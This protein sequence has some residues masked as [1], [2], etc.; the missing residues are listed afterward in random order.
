MKLDI[1]LLVNGTHYPVTIEPRETLLFVLR[2]RLGLTGSKYV[3]GTGECGACTVIVN[4]EPKLSCCSLAAS[5]QGK[6]II[7]I[8][9]LEEDGKLCRL[10]KAFTEEGAIQ[11]GYCTSGMITTAKA[12]LDENPNP[13]REEVTQYLGGNICRCTGYTKI[14]NAVMAAA[15]DGQSSDASKHQSNTGYCVVGKCVMQPDARGKATGRTKYVSDMERPG[16]LHAKVLRSP[17]PHARIT[18]LDVTQARDLPGVAAILAPDDVQQWNP[19]DRGMKD[20]P[21]VAG[22]YVV[23]PE[24]RILNERVRHF[25]D[26]CVAVAAINER[27]A[28]EAL[29]L[30]KVEFEQLPFVLDSQAAMG[31]EA[32]QISV[33][34]EKNIAKEIPYLYPEGDVKQALDEA[35][36]VVQGHFKTGKQEHCT[37]EPAACVAEIDE[38][39]RLIVWSQCQLAHMARRELAHIFKIPLGRIKVNTPQVGGSFGQRGALCAEPICVAL[40]IQTRRPVRLVLSREEHFVGLESRTGFDVELKMGFKQDG[41]LLVAQTHMLGRLGGYMGCGP[42]ASGVGMLLGL[43]HY[44]CPN[45]DGHASMVMTNTPVSGAMRGFGNPTMMW[46]LEQLMDDAAERLGLSPLAIRLKNIKQAGEI[47]GIGTP[48]QSSYLDECILRGAEAI[49]WEHKRGKGTPGKIRRG[50]GMATGSHCSGA[51]GLYIDH[52]NAFIKLNED[53]SADLMVHPGPVGQHIL[54]ALSQIAAEE[55]GVRVEDIRIVQGDTD[56]TMFEFGTDASRSTYV[57]GNAVR[58]TARQAREQVLEYASNMLEVPVAE[59]S[60]RDRLIVSADKEKSIDLAKVCNDAIYNFAGDSLNFFGKSSW[61]GRANSA[62]SGAFFAEVEVDTDTGVVK[63]LKFVSAVDCGKAINPASVEGQV[64][65]AIQQGI[66][67]ALYED[68]V[69]NPDTGAVL[70]DNYD[71]YKMPGPLDMPETEVI[72]IDKPDPAGPFGAKGVGEMGMVGVAPAIANA[73]YDAVG[74]RVRDLPVTP[75]KLLKAMGK[76]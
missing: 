4:G 48:I 13:T 26:A 41:Q 9:G 68:Y 45:K 51:P 46:A 10:Q 60:L 73:I 21:M 43:G 35:D 53:G 69:I 2:E 61:E 64:E 20:L 23:P 57:I 31:E 3:C 34:A 15:N 70:S 1:N 66:G 52:S 62:S 71:T 17:Y 22:G 42:M 40:A 7:T 72:I 54:G 6:K 33:E 29:R 18:N 39:D 50:V 32:P 75:E 25:G 27:V 67:Y 44:R 19:Y 37:E 59:L 36:C 24:E 76:M 5:V 8:E 65:G 14:V 30:I 28:E 16:M 47:G 49:G 55:L 56:V 63:V 12:L 58:N 38:N 74:V 11:C